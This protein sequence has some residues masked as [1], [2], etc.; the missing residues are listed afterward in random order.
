MMGSP[1]LASRADPDDLAELLRRAAHNDARA[2]ARLHAATSAKMRRT[3]LAVCARSPDVDDILQDAYV[4]IWRHAASFDAGRACAITW[5]CAI[6]RNTAID[7][8]RG[9]KLP[10][11]ELDDALGVPNPPDTAEADEFDYALAGGIAFQALERL[12]DAR[13]ELLARAYLEGESRLSLARRFGVPVGTIKTW[14]RRTL[15]AVRKECHAT[16]SAAGLA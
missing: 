7:A 14:L 4:K 8:V 5:M 12:P 1:G 3:V 10:T 16:H 2:F 6:A 13:R 11:L 9:R 15:E